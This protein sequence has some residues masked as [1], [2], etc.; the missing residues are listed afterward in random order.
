MYKNI[1]ED[2]INHCQ[3]PAKIGLFLLK[4]NMYVLS[5]LGIKT[6]LRNESAFLYK[7]VQ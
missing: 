4:D 2:T 6:L 3:N 7:G 1:G 5:S